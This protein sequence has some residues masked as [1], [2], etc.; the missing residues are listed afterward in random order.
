MHQA[1]TVTMILSKNWYGRNLESS[2]I[3][4]SKRVVEHNGIILNAAI[5]ADS[6][7]SLIKF[8]ELSYLS[9]YFKLVCFNKEIAT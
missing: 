7:V 9:S 4:L 5:L 6:P 2:D 3:F 8:S 1:L